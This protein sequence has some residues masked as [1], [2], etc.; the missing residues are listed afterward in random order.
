[1]SVLKNL[2]VLRVTTDAFDIRVGQALCF[3]AAPVLL[4]VALGG[5]ARLAV[6]P[7]EV[8]LGVLGSLTVVLLLVVLGLLL[9]L[10]H[11]KPGT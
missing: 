2:F 10:A 5:L 3:A 7:G 1:M 6:S 4:V 9:P 11:K 8:F